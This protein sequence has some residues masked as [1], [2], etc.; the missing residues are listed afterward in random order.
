MTNVTKEKLL[1]LLG[2]FLRLGSWNSY[3]LAGTLSTLQ[4]DSGPGAVQ[5]TDSYI[6][7]L[8]GMSDV[9]VQTLVE[10]F[11]DRSTVSPPKGTGI[12][13]GHPLTVP[14]LQHSAGLDR[15]HRTHSWL[16]TS[17]QDVPLQAPTTFTQ[18]WFP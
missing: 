17:M 15:R 2:S 13:R 10:P 12:T 7:D 6:C 4:S 1:R 8:C 3:L 9:Y 11:G 18:V 14:R 5:L 16:K